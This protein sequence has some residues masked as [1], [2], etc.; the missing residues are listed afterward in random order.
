VRT[1]IFASFGFATL[2]V[3]FSVRSLDEHIFYY[4]PLSNKYLLGGVFVG[5]V[6]MFA[7]IYVPYLQTLLDTVPLSP[8]WLAAVFG[9]GIVNLFA[10]EMGKWVFIRK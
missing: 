8:V 9:V 3:A 7:G 10:V 5:V 6:L 4:S 1:F 2:F